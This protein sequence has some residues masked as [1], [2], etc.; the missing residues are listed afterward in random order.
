MSDPI[1]ER[2]EVLV[3]GVGLHTAFGD[4]PATWEAVAA[5]RSAVTAFATPEADGFP[6]VAA[7][8]C[9]P[10]ALDDLVPDRKLQKYMGPAAALAVA[11][12]G[13]ALRDAGLLGDAERCAGLALFGATGL[14]GFDFGQVARAMSD[15]AIDGDGATDARPTDGERMAAGLALCHPLIPFRMLLNMPLGLVSIAYGL[16]GENAILYPG[17]LQG[18][19]ALRLAFDAVASGRCDRALAGGSVHGLSLMPLAT[20]R[21]AGRLPASPGADGLAATDAGAY[22]LLE[23]PAAA[24]ERGAKPRAR[25]TDLRAALA[26]E[27]P[28][29]ERMWRASARP[30]G[31]V[32]SS[33]AADAPAVAED[34]RNAHEAGAPPPLRIDPLVGFA[35]AAAP[36]LLVA[37]A[38]LA[39]GEPGAPAR[40]TLSARDPDGGL[41]LAAAE[42]AYGVR[43]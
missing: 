20:A 28:D 41:V 43:A 17:P 19:M 6:S 34:E 39:V 16:R 26:E 4:A 42:R 15:V 21:R 23:S 38:A 24:A 11:A 31:V 12:A 13:R 2:R 37:L 7:A 33:G 30:A 3:T 32:L 8:P 5:G 22:V 1:P 29:R 14:I 27:A 25:L 36:A 9:P 35:G 40:V 18:G 10:P